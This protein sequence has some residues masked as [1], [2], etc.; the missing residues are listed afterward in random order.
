MFPYLDSDNTLALIVS[1]QTSGPLQVD[2]PEIY[3]SLGGCSIKVITPFEIGEEGC[4]IYLEILHRSSGFEKIYPRV[5]SRNWIFSSWNMLGCMSL[6]RLNT[7]A[8]HQSSS[9]I[10]ANI[11]LTENWGYLNSALVK[12]SYWADLA[13]VVVTWTK[14]Q[15]SREG[16][17]LL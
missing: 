15:A 9:E 1:H 16:G 13:M 4:H 14:S 2:C 3:Y 5:I 6:P 12:L 11:L 17:W 7:L 10:T 8:I